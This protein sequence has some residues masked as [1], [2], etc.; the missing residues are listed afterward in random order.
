MNRRE[1]LWVATGAAV[2]GGCRTAGVR[3]NAALRAAVD[4][5][6]AEGLYLG[7]ACASNRGDL[8]V[9]GRRTLD[10]PHLPV[11]ADTLFDLASVG[12]THTAALC[13]LL[14]ADGRLD[15][16]APF[17]KYLPE[18]VLAKENCRITVR[19]L[20]THSG[21]FDN[22]KPYMTPDA[23]KMFA[24]LYRKRPVW[25]RGTRFC[26]ACSNFV[27]LGLIVERLTGMGLDAAAKK[28]LWG[29]LGMTRTTWQTVVDDPNVAEYP[30]STYG[31]ERPGARK[32]RIGERNDTCA[33]LAPCPM[34]NGANF[35]TAPDM[36]LFAT[37]LLRRE[38][39]PKAY[40][41]LL[42]APSFELR[43]AVR[44]VVR[45][46]RAPAQLR[47]G[48]DGGEV[49]VHV[50]D[51]DRILRQGHL[52]HGL[53]GSGDRRRPRARLRRR[54]PRQPPRQQAEDDGPAPAPPR[55]HG[56]KL[57]PVRTRKSPMTLL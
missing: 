39:F 21:G 7:L 47:L 15:V 42:F 13:A 12:K 2:L 22:S 10:E 57:L 41:D 52:P 11:T 45:R 19:D 17:T 29:P 49:D 20:A 27:Y 31:G 36:L 50:L 33:H 54:R 8:Y 25:P 35:S 40:Y 4:G 55:P 37:D 5:Y 51:E 48:H 9:K 26:Y 28:M 46:G 56:V 44:A 18:H 53:D 23:K 34:G 38:R 14:Y 43:P 24:E 30:P 3:D 1:F 32:R 6:V 16:D